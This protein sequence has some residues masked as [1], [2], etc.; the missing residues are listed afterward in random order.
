MVFLET[1]YRLIKKELV[2]TCTESV[3]KRV[4]WRPKR[5]L[6]SVVRAGAGPSS[7]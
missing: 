6:F 4:Y 2:L 3:A 7:R 1:K 5:V